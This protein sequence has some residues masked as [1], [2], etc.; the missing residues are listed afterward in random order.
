MLNSSAVPAEST[1]LKDLCLKSL[2]SSK[3]LD[4]DNIEVGAN[5]SITD[6]MVICTGTSNRHV[7]AIAERLVEYLAKHG[8]SRVTV[9]GEHE[10]KWVL[11]DAGSVIVHI[12][13]ESER[14]RYQL[15]SLYR[16]MAQGIAEN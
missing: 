1:R 3:A 2:D 11:V 9:N 10:G 8:V 14:A 16:C 12:L 6:Y 7:C 13:Q 5:S 15:E 4:L